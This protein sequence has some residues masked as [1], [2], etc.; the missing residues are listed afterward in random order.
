MEVIESCDSIAVS[1]RMRLARNFEGYPF[2]NRLLRDPH[3][4]EQATEMISLISA[5]LKLIDA[6]VLY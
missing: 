2:P 5:E 3:A 4:A 1:T 6:F